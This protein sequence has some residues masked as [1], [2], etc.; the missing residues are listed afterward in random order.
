[1]RI[2]IYRFRFMSCSLS[3]LVD[4]LSEL[5]HDIKCTNRKSCLEYISTED[6]K[7]LIFN[8]LKCSKN[9]KKHFNKKLIN[10]FANTYEFSKG[11]INKFILLLRKGAYPYESMDSWERFDE[12]YCLKKKAFTLV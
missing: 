4:N 2:K 12:K 7:L 6:D 3:N 11:D 9:H 8:C 1:M 5:L 10:K